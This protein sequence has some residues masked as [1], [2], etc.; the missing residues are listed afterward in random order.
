MTEKIQLNDYEASVWGDVGY[1]GGEFSYGVPKL[2]EENRAGISLLV[3]RGFVS[4]DRQ[5]DCW[6]VSVTEA[7]REVS[8]RL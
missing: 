3:L 2:T 6:D 4:V 1:H 8:D 7:G 5:A